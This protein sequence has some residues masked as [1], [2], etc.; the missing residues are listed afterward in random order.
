MNPATT[1]PRSFG[2]KRRS[3][4]TI[5]AAAMALAAAQTVSFAEECDDCWRPKIAKYDCR[6]IPARPA[7]SAG[8]IVDWMGL[9]YASA[10]VK[11]YFQNID[12]TKECVTYLDGSFFTDGDTAANSIKTGV[13][14]TNLPSQEGAAGGDYLITGSVDGAPGSYTCTVTLQVS[15]TREEVATAT[16]DFI[17][18][19]SS[20]EAG[21]AAAEKIGPVVE[22]IRAF[23]KRKRELG[24]PYALQPTV[25]LHPEKSVV[26]K[27]ESV[28]VEV[29]LW[30]CDGTIETSP[31]ADRPVTL[32]A[33]GGT[34]DPEEV[35]TG[36]D[37]KATSTFTAGDKEMEAVIEA[38]YP[39]TTATG[40]ESGAD[41][42]FS[43]ISI[44][45]PDSPEPP[46]PT[47]WRVQGI[48]ASMNNSVQTHH[49]AAGGVVEHSSVSSS[50]EHRYSVNGIIR[51][52]GR[53]SLNVFKSD[54]APVSCR[55][56]GSVSEFGRKWEYV[57]T[58]NGS[59]HSWQIK[60]ASGFPTKSSDP[61]PSIEFTFR[62]TGSS[63][64]N[65]SVRSFG[66]RGW[67][68]NGPSVNV[69]ASCNKD[70]CDDLGYQSEIS[71]SVEEF[72]GTLSNDDGHNRDTS[73]TDGTEHRTVSEHNYI[74][75][76]PSDSSFSIYHFFKQ[77]I[78]ISPAEGTTIE[79]TRDATAIDQSYFSIERIGG[80]NT[81][82]LPKAATSRRAPF[83]PSIRSRGSLLEISASIPET[84]D[85]TV[86]LFDLRGRM[87]ASVNQK[88]C[89]RGERRFRIEHD[90]LSSGVLCAR[91]ELHPAAGK[92]VTAA[93]QL[94]V[95][96]Q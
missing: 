52:I 44:K 19:D 83:R 66:V 27:N 64:K 29:W 63:G 21:R 14:W 36:D 9:F 87:V 35:N 71:G 24:H 50:N 53:D 85:L 79:D 30:D 40:Y 86:R 16:A 5:A 96:N 22:A 12:P 1:G 4:V 93:A 25:E 72:I 78:H 13:Q 15:K 74:K 33:E 51:N 90:A 54:T 7:D 80:R 2:A 73:Y 3:F 91:F 60:N 77:I 38:Q 82:A 31:L 70:G 59:T 18:G 62:F 84:G 28:E 6:V 10:G 8:L 89:L 39:F 81:A 48:F 58:P 69:G 23:E 46:P 43:A 68:I 42:G 65:N 67:E 95:V 49:A 11:D 26:D 76:D 41:G 37:G 61:E 45:S 34:F 55:M 20:I 56:S 57:K 75:V 47:L 17:S 32:R 88:N 94:T 92:A